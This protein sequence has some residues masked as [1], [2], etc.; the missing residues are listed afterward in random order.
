M[1]LPIRCDACRQETMVDMDKMEK[2]PVSNLISAEGFVC[3][4]CK[5]WKSVFYITTSLLDAMRKLDDTSPT[6]RSFAWRFT[7]VLLKARAIQLIGEQ[8]GSL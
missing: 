3:E 8:I 7:K 1:E 2:R 4:H 6:N 5:S